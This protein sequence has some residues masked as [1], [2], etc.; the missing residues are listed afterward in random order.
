MAKRTIQVTIIS[1][2]RL[3]KCDAACGVDWSLAEAINLA[4]QRIKERFGEGAQL[5][6]F[7]IAQASNK[8]AQEYQKLATSKELTLPLLLIDGEP[9]ISGEFD[10]RQ[11][12][13]VVEAALE[14]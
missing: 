14:M 9:R 2:S 13:D 8:K 5:E 1:D 10:I 11:L 6:S 4:R 7:D 12:L 3:K